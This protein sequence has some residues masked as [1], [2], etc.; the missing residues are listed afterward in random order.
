M[1]FA[2]QLRKGECLNYQGLSKKK[3]GGLVSRNLRSRFVEDLT[4]L[5]SDKPP[6]IYGS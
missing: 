6:Y 4:A 5:R 3:Y 1:L 2:S